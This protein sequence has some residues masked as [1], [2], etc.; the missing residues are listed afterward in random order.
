MTCDKKKPNMLT[1]KI[2]MHFINVISYGEV[3]LLLLHFA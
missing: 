3:G 2:L 1:K